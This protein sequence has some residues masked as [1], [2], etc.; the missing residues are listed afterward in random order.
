[1]VK[2]LQL[3]PEA[4][5]ASGRQG[6]VQTGPA[7]YRKNLCLIITAGIDTSQRRQ[8]LHNL[9]ITRCELFETSMKSNL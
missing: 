3:R 9:C 1:M 8:P 2:T 5:G 7:A 6:N 4:A